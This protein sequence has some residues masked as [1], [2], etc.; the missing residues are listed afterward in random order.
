MLALR[1]QYNHNEKTYGLD[2]NTCSGIHSPS[3]LDNLSP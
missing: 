1:T 2:E 3:T